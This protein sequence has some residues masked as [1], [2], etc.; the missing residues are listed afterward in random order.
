MIK[1]FKLKIEMNM[2]KNL[3]KIRKSKN[4]LVF[5]KFKK[6]KILP[7]KKSNQMTPLGTKKMKSFFYKNYVN[8]NLLIL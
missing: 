4:F 8:E 5:V 1:I 2:N 7:L 3:Q 6:M